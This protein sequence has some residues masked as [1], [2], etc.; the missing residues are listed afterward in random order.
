MN[1]A[2]ISQHPDFKPRTSQ[3]QATQLVW[4]G[5][6]VILLAIIPI[7]LWMVLAPLS[8]AV[9]APAYV[10][11]DLNRR[12][13]QH[14]EGGIVSA[15]LVRD[16]QVVKAGEP[17]LLLG[18]VGVEA[19]RNRLAY[20]VQVERAS[21]ARLEAMQN[22]AGTLVFPQDL[23]RAAQQDERIRQA[24]AKETALFEARRGSLV[25]EVAL[26]KTQRDRMEDEIVGLRAQI[27]S[28][29][30][31]HDSQAETLDANRLLLKDGFIAPTRIQQ[32]EAGVSDYAVKL[33]STRTE[34]A[35]AQQ[36]VVEIDL[37]IKSIQ[38][39]YIKQAS[40]QLKV[41]AAQLGEIEQERRKSDD[42][43]VRQ[44]VTAPASGE[45]IDLKFTSPGAVIRPGD[46][47]A[48]IVPHDAARMIEAQIRPEDIN[49][50]QREQRARIQFTAM[51]FRNSP[52][53]TGKVTYVSADRFI[54][55]ATNMPYYSVMILADADSV[56]A[57]SD[58]KLQ[59][60]MPAEVYIEGTTQT[61]LQ[62]MI[63]PITDTMRK[64][65]RQM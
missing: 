34:V 36:R 33:E 3:Q 19:D 12:P 63:A 10:K 62:Y 58:L 21:L 29:Q 35:R 28:A 55:R 52:Q 16:G 4:G 23:I 51:K 18:D 32:L 15:V 20:R 59:A 14:R 8:M 54:D 65:A 60:G 26:M 40:D 5:W 47:I 43:A 1:V 56:Q 17:I 57:I 61:P 27:V 39:E 2:A 31:S 22:L 11:V 64:A 9:V 7:S 49:N 46:P 42:A 30:R 13:V 24:L 53:V 6:W 48:D 37:K 44:A 50:I 45:V 41:V 38:N 25:S